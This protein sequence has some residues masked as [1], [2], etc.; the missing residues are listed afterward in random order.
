MGKTINLVKHYTTQLSRFSRLDT[1]RIL[2]LLELC[3]FVIVGVFMGVISSKIIDKYISI[4]YVESTYVTKDY[5]ET[6]KNNSPILYLHIVYDLFFVAISSYYLTKLSQIIPFTLAF[7]H[8]EYLPNKKGEGN[9]GLI[10]G[11]GMVYARGLTNLQKRLDL[12]IGGIE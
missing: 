12:L 1:I 7:A 5:P 10:I 6:K 2:K 8:N 9:S 11:L 4:T 3:Q